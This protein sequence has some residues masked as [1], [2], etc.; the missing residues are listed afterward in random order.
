MNVFLVG[1]FSFRAGDECK[2]LLLEIGVSSC[3]LEKTLEPDVRAGRNL[4]AEGNTNVKKVQ[5]SDFDVLHLVNQNHSVVCSKTE[6]LRG[7]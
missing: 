1:V 5:F 2:A 6:S 4:K 3:S 7:L